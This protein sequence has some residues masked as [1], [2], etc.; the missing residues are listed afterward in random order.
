MR[1]VNVTFSNKDIITTNIN[2]TDSEIKDYYKVG[3]IFNL[4]SVEDKMAYVVSCEILN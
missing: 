2:G 1:A 3:R 4:G